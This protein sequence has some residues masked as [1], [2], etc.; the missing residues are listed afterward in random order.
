MK[1]LQRATLYYA[2][3]F[4]VLLMVLSGFFYGIIQFFFLKSLDE[5][6]LREKQKVD[7]SFSANKHPDQLVFDADEEVEIRPVPLQEKQADS[8]HTIY[9]KDEW[10]TTSSL[11]VESEPH[12]ELVTF[13]EHKDTLYK[14]TIRKS[15]IESEDLLSSI[16]LIEILVLLILMGSFLLVNVW[17]SKRLWKSF[18]E[19]LNKIKKYNLSSGDALVLEKSSIREFEDLNSVLQ[20]MSARIQKDYRVQKQFTENASHELQTPLMVIRSKIELLIQR[21]NLSE[22][23]MRLLQSIDN[24]SQKLS[25]INKALLLL[26]RIE[27]NQFS[28]NEK[29]LLQPLISKIVEN[30]TDRV[31]LKK[32]NLE[33][34]VAADAML[35]LDPTLAEIL[36]T[37]L[38]QNAV[39]HNFHGGSIKIVVRQGKA[40]FSNTGEILDFDQQAV[41]ERFRKSIKSDEGTGLGLAIVKEICNV[42]G[43]T[44]DYKYESNQHF[45]ILTW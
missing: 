4:L 41:F 32:L 43:I 14:L 25:H 23:Q 18:Y 10:D 40:E 28:K 16:V 8:Y 31:H 5:S 3:V 36:F 1:L 17:I 29:I 13:L 44:I 15:M 33:L 2:I 12:R 19:V 9:F 21:P 24:A 30:F 39:R 27:N 38:I 35:N 20:T 37:N 42:G 7:Y 6:L 34:N 45:F 11:Q 22:D 26:S